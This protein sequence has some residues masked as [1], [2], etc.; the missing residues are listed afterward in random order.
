M[1]F[2]ERPKRALRVLVVDD[3]AMVRQAMTSILGRDGSIEVTTAGDP[4]FA[5]AKMQRERPD[6]I[7]TDIEMPRMNGLVFLRQI[8]SRDPIPTIICS[9]HT[10]A[11]IRTAINALEEG[12]I[13]V[14]TK[15]QI[16]VRE[17]LEESAVT[18][19]DAVRAAGAVRRTR[20]VRRPTH[21][22]TTPIRRETPFK[23]TGS[24]G[25]S[26][27]V[28]V[29]GASAGGTEALRE[30]LEA[31]PAGCPGIVV[32][33]HMPEG[34]T[35]A[36]AERLDRSCRI[37]V[38]EAEDGDRV[39]D[40]RALIAPGDRHTRLERG[41][42][43]FRVEVSGGP[44]VSRHRPSVDVL[45]C[46]AARVARDRAVGV[47]LT[48]MG[49]DGARGLHEMKDAGAPTIAQDEATCVVFGM[50]KEAIARGAVDEISP[51][52]EIASRMLR[53]A[54]WSSNPV[55]QSAQL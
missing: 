39:L 54:G 37:E 12:A 19:I 23:V 2:F 18:L 29:I 28:I 42:S 21:G 32:V 8:M 17:F 6:V 22:L 25:A 49:D 3:S 10:G 33:Q 34:F 4:V 43:H 36:F 52:P 45:F 46:S 16:G 5:L 35:R 44:L 31:M 20:L 30:I 13:S 55:S 14:V 48:G 38:R 1:P 15:P 7:V 26:R 11:V 51:L 27:N 53:R 9:S 24:G 50:P 47:L 40:G 41:G